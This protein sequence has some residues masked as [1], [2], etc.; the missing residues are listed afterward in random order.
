MTL[1]PAILA[2][3]SA[4]GTLFSVSTAALEAAIPMAV[5]WK[6][7]KPAQIEASM[8][9]TKQSPAPVSLTTDAERAG[10]CIAKRAELFSFSGET[11]NVFGGQLEFI[12]LN[13]WLQDL[14]FLIPSEENFMKLGPPLKHTNTPW[15][16]TVRMT[17]LMP[18]S[19]K[20][21]TAD[22]SS[23][24]R[25]SI[26]HVVMLL[27]RLIGEN[28]SRPD[29]ALAMAISSSSLGEA[30]VIYKNDK[31]YIRLKRAENQ[32]VVN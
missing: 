23:W 20:T 27:S 12:V 1:V 29:N 22:F 18:F 26:E 10:K 28:K 11:E 31:S 13:S 2:E 7:S 9:P 15:E 16:P 14:F 4:W 32:M 24:K 19:S 25:D 5:L 30:K 17:I 21:H 8:P 6:I 3:W